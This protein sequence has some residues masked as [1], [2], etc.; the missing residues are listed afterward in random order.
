MDDASTVFIIL[1]LL[2]YTAVAAA[3]VFV[4]VRRWIWPLVKAGLPHREPVERHRPV[5]SA[6]REHSAP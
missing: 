4:G 3:F 5:Q 1:V 2:F 6:D